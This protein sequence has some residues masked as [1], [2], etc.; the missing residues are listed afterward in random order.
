MKEKEKEKEVDAGGREQRKVVFFCAGQYGCSGEG[1]AVQR[2]GG[3]RVWT[4][5]LNCVTEAQERRENRKVVLNGFHSAQHT[6]NSFSTPSSLSICQERN[7]QQHNIYLR[8]IYG[9]GTTLF[10]HYFYLFIQR[11]N[12]RPPEQLY[13]ARK[14]SST[15]YVSHSVYSISSADVRLFVF[16]EQ[17]KEIRSVRKKK[18]VKKKK[19]AREE[20]ERPLKPTMQTS[21]ESAFTSLHLSPLCF[22]ISYIFL[23]ACGAAMATPKEAQVRVAPTTTHLLPAS[24]SRRIPNPKES[25]AT[26]ALHR[27]TVWLS[28]LLGPD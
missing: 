22:L 19:I 28:S 20:E 4:L 11:K 18:E 5:I 16:E 25:Q 27:F 2:E 10:C 8:Y 7:A 15:P 12:E 23:H 21:G 26:Y 13:A 14:H 17:E 24:L 6:V 9:L 3:K 1:R